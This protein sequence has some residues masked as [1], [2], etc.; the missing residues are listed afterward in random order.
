MEAPKQIKIKMPKPHEKVILHDA[1]NNMEYSVYLS[2]EDAE[3]CKNDLA[4]A[5]S[6]LFHAKCTKSYSNAA[7]PVQQQAYSAQQSPEDIDVEH[8]NDYNNPPVESEESVQEKT[9]WTH[10]ET[11][12][13]IS[14]YEDHLE[15]FKNAKRR[16]KVWE[17]I[18]TAL[19]ETGISHDAGRCEVKWKNLLRTYKSIKDTKK[20][21]GRGTVKFLY[22]DRLDGILSERPV[23]NCTHTFSSTSRNSEISEESNN[24]VGDN[25]TVQISH[26]TVE[27]VVPPIKSFKERRNKV[28]ELIN[29]KIDYYKKKK[30]DAEKKDV[31]KAEKFELQKKL[32]AIEEKKVAILEDY[33]KKA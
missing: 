21:T 10:N 16:K 2:Y 20:K 13:L 15:D 19:K 8:D 26:Q 22:F 6:L 32:V 28:N 25:S 29:L 1:V 33:L 3:K 18:S 7:Q 14:A 27:A 23:M 11:L 4:F 9:H 30:V 12:A 31:L 24:D 17:K 5:N